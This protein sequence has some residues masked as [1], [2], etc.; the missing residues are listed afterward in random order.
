[1]IKVGSTILS[2]NP[3]GGALAGPENPGG[4]DAGALETIS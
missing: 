2:L 4:A 3:G 1:M